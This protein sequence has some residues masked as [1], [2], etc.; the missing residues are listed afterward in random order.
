MAQ[1]DTA[2]ATD[3]ASPDD[4]L[5]SEPGFIGFESLADGTTLPGTIAGLDF[6]TTG[7]HTWLVG[8]FATGHYNGKY[9]SGSYM[10]QGTHW[11][12]LG[13]QQGAGRINMANGPAS[14][15]SLLTSVGATP[16]SLEAFDASGN[17]LASA[18]P[19][20]FNINTGHMTELKITRSTP[21]IAYVIVHDTGN[22]FLVDSI[23]TDAPGVSEN[24]LPG[25]PVAVS[26]NPENG[27]A[28]VFWKPP[29]NQG[30]SPILKYVITAKPYGNTDS[31]AKPKVVFET[32]SAAGSGVQLGEIFGLLEDCHQEYTFTVS[33]VNSSGE[34]PPSLPGTSLLPDQPSPPNSS[35][36]PSHFRTSGIV[37]HYDNEPPTVVVTVDGFGAHYD[38][39][40][41]T[42]IDPLV[43]G[44]KVSD[45]LGNGPPVSYCFEGEQVP[46]P[47]TQ[48]IS[49][50][51][52][53]REPDEH[54][55]QPGGMNPGTFL[56]DG[57]FTGTHHYLL[58][59]LVAEGGIA[60]PYSYRR[61]AEV[62]LGS[63]LVPQFEFTGYSERE[64]DS[65]PVQ[66]DVALLATEVESIHRAWPGT[67]I[68]ILGHSGGGLV[69]EQ[70]W[71]TR[72]YVSQHVTHVV[73]IEGPINGTEYTEE[74]YPDANSSACAAFSLASGKGARVLWFLGKQWVN[75]E[76]DDRA[77]LQRDSDHSFTAI[78]TE[79]DSAYG[80]KTN[81]LFDSVVPDSVFSCNVTSLPF[82]INGCYPSQPPSFVDGGVFRS[83]DPCEWEEELEEAYGQDGSHSYAIVCRQNVDYIRTLR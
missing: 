57:S 35:G 31:F 61:P 20:T 18:G 46:F 53:I 65:Q 55:D 4:Y 67:K 40:V 48:N 8:D 77:I 12:W 72:D 1:T 79:G 36:A 52:T 62:T 16:V 64:S 60:L 56:S 3:I 7:G 70:Y 43:G 14:Y 81:G 51:K 2:T 59:Q 34:G 32:V 78:S 39:G 73:S 49:V 10:S 15:F 22:F 21:D 74:C 63:N 30:S 50:P 28:E 69:A 80:I 23:C 42:R 82:Q 44:G 38:N 33:A 75:Q 13:E 6:V 19:A 24:G 9:P 11:A 17:L 66:K 68:I 25:T 5:C 29:V 45:A 47:G 54:F 58:D 27:Y 83:N 76:S 37:A 71:Q 26:V 41:T